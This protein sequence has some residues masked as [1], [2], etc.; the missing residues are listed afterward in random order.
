MK[1][2]VE[3]GLGP[4][5][6]VLDGDRAPPKWAQPP[7]QFSARICY[8]QTAVWIKM[9]LGTKVGLG[10]GQIVLDGTQLPTKK[11]HSPRFSAHLSYW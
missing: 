1:L 10:P 2:G 8:G 7:P 5:H 9:S 3:V 6:I 4:G 11:R